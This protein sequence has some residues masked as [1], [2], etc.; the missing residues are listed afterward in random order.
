MAFG[1]DQ[2]RQLLNGMSRNSS[3]T[4]KYIA[5]KFDDAVG[6]KYYGFVAKGGNWYIMKEVITGVIS[7]FTYNTG[8]LANQSVEA[9]ETAWTGRAALTYTSGA[10]TKIY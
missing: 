10:L 3:P 7:V 8:T 1:V 5:D 2:E 4:D 6:T 9:Y